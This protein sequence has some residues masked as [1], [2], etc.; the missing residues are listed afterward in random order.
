M[1]LGDDKTSV[2]HKHFDFVLEAQL[3]DLWQHGGTAAGKLQVVIRKQP[4]TNSD[5]AGQLKHFSQWFYGALCCIC[6]A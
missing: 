1:S 5:K 3:Q 4:T 2:Q 6:L